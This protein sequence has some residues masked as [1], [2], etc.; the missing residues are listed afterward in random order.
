M[1]TPISKV[2]I[3]YFSGTGNARHVSEWFAARSVE[4]GVAAEVV[5]IDKI[6][7]SSVPSTIEGEMLGIIGPTHGFNYPPILVNFVLRI[8]RAQSNHSPVF[9]MN[10]RAGMKMG[11]LF[12]P[13]LSGIAL[14]FAATVLRI[15]GYSIVGLRSIDLPSN[16]MSLHPA[17]SEQVV[18]SIFAR[19][20][21]IVERFADRLLAG[22]RDYRACRDIIADLLISPISILYYL[23]GRFILAKTFYADSRCNHCQICVQQCPVKAIKMVNGSP[24]WTYRCESCMRC[25]NNCPKNAVETAHGYIFAVV[26]LTYSTAIAW[27]WS[28]FDVLTGIERGGFWI[29]LA[30]FIAESIVVFVVLIAGYRIIHYL[31]RLPVLRQLLEFTSFT[32]F[33][34][35]GRYKGLK[36]MDAKER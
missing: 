1:K 29:E 15:K 19:C 18:V 31:K 28:K 21:P 24:F 9:L 13:G 11:K 8:P 23:I 16:W 3:Y 6:D 30:G 25:M 22:K 14:W 27:L 4:N 35:W 32:R 33:R 10:T 7:R 34:F 20:R 36:K 2:K 26:F 17:L 12:L 5:N